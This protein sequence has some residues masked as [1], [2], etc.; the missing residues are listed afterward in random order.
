MTVGGF[1]GILGGLPVIWGNAVHENMISYPMPGWL[2]VACMFSVPLGIGIIGIA[3]KGQDEHSTLEQ[4]S[5][6]KKE[7]EEK[8]EETK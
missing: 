4:V 7:K 6:V 3:G 8:S 5:K 2:Y 1:I